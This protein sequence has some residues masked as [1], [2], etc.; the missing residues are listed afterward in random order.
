MQSKSDI[1]R[2]VLLWPILFLMHIVA[3]TPWIVINAIA[4]VSV[5]FMWLANRR[6]RPITE[7]NVAICFPDL[8]RE[9]Q[10]ELVKANLYQTGMNAFDMARCWMR[11][12]E[13][14]EGRISKIDGLE[15]LMVVHDVGLA[16]Q[17]CGE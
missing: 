5:W 12:R 4:H 11:S 13:Y 9:R 15:H 2:S 17:V 10:H 3:R 7:V 14:L 8:S 1:V 16:Q 6:A